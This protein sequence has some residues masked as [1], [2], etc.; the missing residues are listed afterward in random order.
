MQRSH[1]E[2][3]AGVPMVKIVRFPGPHAITV[4]VDEVT[5]TIAAIWEQGT[6]DIRARHPLGTLRHRCAGGG[7]GPVVA[8]HRCINPDLSRSHACGSN[9]CGAECDRCGDCLGQ[10]DDPAVYWGPYCTA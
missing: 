8:V 3:V 7:T 2:T 9:G 5:D 6:R 10:T 4:P 1:L